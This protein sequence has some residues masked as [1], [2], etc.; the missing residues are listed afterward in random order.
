MISLEIL[1]TVSCDCDISHVKSVQLNLRSIFS[2]SRFLKCL[3]C[4][5]F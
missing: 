2:F 3:H 1:L 4:L 5:M